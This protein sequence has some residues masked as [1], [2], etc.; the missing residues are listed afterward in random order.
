M[1]TK[2]NY[3]KVERPHFLMG[4]STALS[5]TQSYNIMAE[6]ILVSIP[7]HLIGMPIFI[8][9]YCIFY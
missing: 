4:S 8:L 5:T 6:L 2:C 1:E 9:I 3:A 7:I